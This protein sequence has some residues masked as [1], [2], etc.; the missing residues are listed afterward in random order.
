MQKIECFYSKL[1][2][3]V[4]LFYETVLKWISIRNFFY[5]FVTLKIIHKYI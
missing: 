2:F 3:L 5:N 1:E 4:T